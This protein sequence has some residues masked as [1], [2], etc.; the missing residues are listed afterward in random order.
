MNWQ[1]VQGSFRDPSGFVYTRDGT[2]YRQVNNTF[3]Q[4]FEAFLGSGLYHELVHDGLLVPHKSVSLELSATPDACAVLQPEKVPFVS[5][6]YEWSF[7]QLQDAALL[8]LEIQERALRRGFSLRDSSAYNV[9]F[10]AG[11]PIFIDTLSFEPVQEGRPWAAYK[12]F[13]EHFLLPLS[14]MSR[15]DI[16][17]GTLL[18]SYLNGIPLDL[19]SR[20]LPRL[21]WLSPSTVL[22]IHLHA[23]VQARYAGAAVSTAA[24]GRT[25]SPRALLSLIKNLAG[26]IRRLSWRAA[27]TEWADYTSEN[28][29]SEQASRSKRTLVGS[30]LS[31]SA[32]QT[33]WDLGANTGEYSR[34]AL[35]TASQVVAFDLDP[36]AV[37]R[38]YRRIREDRTTGILPLLLDLTNPSPAQGWAGR[39]RLSL[40]DRGP[41]DAVLALA[42]I[43][44]LAIGHNLPLH[45]VSEYLGR[46]G[47]T[48]II[49]FVPKSDPQ[50]QRLLLSRPDIF[51][52][53][54]KEGFEAA[55]CRHYEI[56]SVAR[57]ED[58]ERWLYC[59][60]ARTPPE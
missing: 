41:A 54:S 7:G 16:R 46:L 58:S 36:A 59:M 51:P 14:L 5:Y 50:V 10:Q 48:L 2:L 55:F 52:E 43:H 25:M 34:V 23:R 20:L 44:H 13:C 37:E 47:R 22:H 27:G 17:C 26:A 32:A 53:Y 18:R 4:Q 33:V 8:T 39:E 24:R 6:P 56:Q 9:Q 3:R 49:E 28:T 60:T 15:V 29:Y 30:Y 40:E 38:N 45:R 11:R 12:Q 1:A 19:G 42:L 57:I 31:K 35:E 21:S